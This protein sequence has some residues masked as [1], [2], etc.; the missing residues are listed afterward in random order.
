MPN[1]NEKMGLLGV[2]EK[3]LESEHERRRSYLCQAKL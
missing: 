3:L 2:S 1:A